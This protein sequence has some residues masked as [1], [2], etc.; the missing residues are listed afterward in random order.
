LVQDLGLAPGAVVTQA[1]W[2]GGISPPASHRTVLETLASYGSSPSLKAVAFR[3]SQAHP[4]LPALRFRVDPSHVKG[5]TPFA[6]P[7]L[8][9]FQRYYGAVR[10]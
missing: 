7:S 8:Q 6:P 2:A 3:Y 10:T 5:A 4:L 9:R 1:E